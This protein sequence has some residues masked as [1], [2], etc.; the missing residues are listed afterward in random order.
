MK[1]MI[2][3]D[4]DG[5]LL[6]SNGTISDT[7]L[8]TLENLGSEG[9]CRVI[10]T[11]RSPFSLRKTFSSADLPIDYLVF[12]S[13]AGIIE[14]KTGKLILSYNLT[15]HQ[16]KRA[17]NHLSYL[18]LD[19]FI[20][21]PVPDNHKC[22]YVRASYH[23]T[24]FERRVSLYEE[25]AEDLTGKS[26]E[27]FESCQLIAILNGNDSV[28]IFNE[29]K[30]YFHDLAVIRST[31]PLDHTSLWL[32]IYS[33]EVSKANGIKYLAELLGINQ[34]D[35][36]AV[37]NDYNDIDMLRWAGHGYAVKNA[38]DVMKDEFIPVASHK[39]SGFTEAV[40]R[41]LRL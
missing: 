21:D 3:T 40:N 9:Y 38:P 7:D 15:E 30:A 13:G 28:K 18:G 1:K 12:S 25:F 10:A 6:N 22:K 41:W 20:L 23:N 2:V 29:V 36:M 19:F 16:V 14:W 37:G 17:Y 34:K 33:P 27:S 26:F 24:D 11:G 31:S 39:D 8:F 5:T 4:L 35:I 32:E